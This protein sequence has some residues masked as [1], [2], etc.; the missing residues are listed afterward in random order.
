MHFRNT[1]SVL[2]CLLLTAC[3]S[4]MPDSIRGT[5][6]QS[7]SAAQVQQ[8]P[9]RFAGAKVRWGGQIMSVKN[10]AG[11]TRIEVLSRELDSKGEPRENSPAGARFMAEVPG[12]L[13]PEAYAE[14]RSITLVGRCA[15][16]QEGKIGEFLYQYPM[17]QADSHHLWPIKVQLPVVYPMFYDPWHVPWWRRY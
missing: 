17:I 12:F 3:N 10:L 15:G 16:V 9:S 1:L 6:T 8:N 14:K 2:F 5:E 7:V 4:L 13:D 11:S